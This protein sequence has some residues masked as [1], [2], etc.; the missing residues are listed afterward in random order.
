MQGADVFG[1]L[2]AESHSEATARIRRG[3]G[4][5]A[6]DVEFIIT[7]V[8]ALADDWRTVMLLPQIRRRGVERCMPAFRHGGGRSCSE[9]HE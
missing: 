4:V 7:V 9:Q 8:V 2:Q 3:G 1:P 5:A 6:I